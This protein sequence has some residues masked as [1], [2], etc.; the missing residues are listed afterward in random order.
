MFRQSCIYGQR[1]L[2][3]EDQGWLAWLIIASIFDKPITIFGDGKQVR[4]MLHVSD[5]VGLYEVAIEKIDQCSGQVYNIGGGYKNTISVW[6]E[7]GLILEKKLDKKI[8]VN[9]LDWR[10]GD[11][12]VWCSDISK[13]KKDFSWEPK[14]ELEKGIDAQIEWTIKNRSLIDKVF[15]SMNKK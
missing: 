5:L 13:A 3:V 9:Y 11:Q 1:Q 14:M 7:L 12:K 15:G 10:P 2:G 8:S 6:K 4:D